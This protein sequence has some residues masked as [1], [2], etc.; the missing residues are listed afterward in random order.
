MLEFGL[1]LAFRLARM[2]WAMRCARRAQRAG[3]L[4]VRKGDDVLRREA[5]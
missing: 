4:R 5:P 3:G 1:L 2:R